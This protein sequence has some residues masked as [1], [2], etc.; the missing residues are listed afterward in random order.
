MYKVV[1]KLILWYVA[2]SF[3]LAATVATVVMLPFLVVEV[4]EKFFEEVV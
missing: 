4:V 1:E 3:V 2:L